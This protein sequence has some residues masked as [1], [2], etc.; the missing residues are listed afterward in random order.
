[1]GTSATTNAGNDNSSSDR[2]GA[3]NTSGAAGT[4]RPSTIGTIHRAAEVVYCS[5][6]REPMAIS[7]RAS[8]SSVLTQ[9]TTTPSI[10]MES[11]AS[12]SSNKSTASSRNPPARDSACT[13]GRGVNTISVSNPAAGGVKVGH[14]NR[15]TGTPDSGTV[16]SR[17]RNALRV[18]S[19]LKITP[20]P[21]ERTSISSDADR[22][23]VKPTP[24]CPTPGSAAAFA[25][26]RSAVRACTPDTSSAAPVLATCSAPASSV[27]TESRPGTPARC[28]ASAAFCAN[29][30]NKRSRYPP[31]TRSAS[32][33]ES[34]R[35]RV[36]E[37][38]QDA[39][40]DSRSDP[41]PKGSISSAMPNPPA[42]Q[43]RRHW[44]RRRDRHRHRHR[45][46]ETRRQ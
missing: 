38:P 3:R 17:S 14:A 12:S 44:N 34:S 46:R 43:H 11:N 41:V 2:V 33:A 4:G 30:V 6:V 42:A 36:G 20:P 23:A 27:H 7:T 31:R 39:R 24:N 25:D 45:L 5:H 1:M 18:R 9:S 19:A 8:S 28:A 29:S 32:D 21:R 26:A 40:I 22:T 15:S 35:S 37:E 16:M 10:S 13:S